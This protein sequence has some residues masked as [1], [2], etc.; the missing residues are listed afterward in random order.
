MAL[1][2]PWDIFN[3]KIDPIHMKLLIT[4]ILD[5]ERGGEDERGKEW[6]FPYFLFNLTTIPHQLPNLQTVGFST[7]ASNDT[8]QLLTPAQDSSSV[9]RAQEEEDPLDQTSETTE[10]APVDTNDHVCI[11]GI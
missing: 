6:G 1:R 3:L 4:A 7:F 8:A 11:P 2:F 10:K 9:L 5:E